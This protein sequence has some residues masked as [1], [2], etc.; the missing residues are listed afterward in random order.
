MQLTLLA[1]LRH[2]PF[3]L[4]FGGQVISNLG[5]WLD[6]LALLALLIYEWQLGAASWGAVLMALTVPLAVVGPFAGVWADRWP[7]RTV[8]IVCDLAR[9]LIVLG[10]VWAS[11]VVVVVALVALAS[12]FSAFF[13]PAQKATIRAT[14]PDA[15]L[16][17]ANA[18]S[19]LSDNAGRLIGPAVG[20]ALVALV[21]PRGAFT[22]DA[23]S[24][25]ASAAFLSRLPTLPTVS[26]AN[27][28]PAHFWRDL[29]TGWFHVARNP[30]LLISACAT[31]AGSFLI[32]STDTLG[33]VVD[34][35]LGLT[36]EV[37]G[38]V[39]VA[40]GAGYITGSLVVG[41]W[42]QRFRPFGIMGIARL[43]VGCAVAAPG[44]GLLVG[45]H[46]RRAA[47]A[48]AIPAFLIAGIGFAATGIASAYLMQRETSHDLMGRVSALMTALDQAISLPAPIIATFLVDRFGLAPT[49]VAVCAIVMLTGLLLLLIRRIDSVADAAADADKRTRHAV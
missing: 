12:L 10:L 34:R 20:G 49:Y 45:V 42:G 1:P 24:F 17:A 14:V 2:R 39:F 11:N 7:R 5:D 41:Q 27:D 47:L 18:L 19:R 13:G 15:D 25:L 33:S 35:S 3:R 28:A 6:I 44:I 40:S 26:T 8:M 32:R 38:F 22:A 37:L 30:L 31:A 16:L 29:R 9:A 21:G 48:V 46:G 4:L 43:V 36:Q 23:L